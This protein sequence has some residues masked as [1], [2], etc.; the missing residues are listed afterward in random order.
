MTPSAR[1]RPS[2]TWSAAAAL[3]AV[4]VVRAG[5]TWWVSGAH[6]S[7]VRSPDTPG[8]VTP[9][10]SLLDSGVFRAYPGRDVPM[11][12][13]TPG[14]PAFL[15]G[16]IGLTGG[17]RGALMVQVFVSILTILVTYLLVIRLGGSRVAAGVAAAIV[18]LDPLQFV[19]SGTLLTESVTSLVMVAILAAGVGLFTV[20]AT[21]ARVRQSALLGLA[22]AIATM[23][24]PTT[25]YLPVLIVGLLVVHL[26]RSGLRRVVLHLAAFLLPVFVVVGAWQVRN[27]RVVNSWS[28]SQI[29][30]IN[31]YCY[32]G[33]S[34]EAGARN[35]SLA[36]VWKQRGC[37]ADGGVT[38]WCPSLGGCDE[39]VPRTIGP[40]F[41]EL[42][43]QGVRTTLHYP[44]ETAGS[45]VRGGWRL[46][47][48][49]GTETVARFLAVE[50]SSL[51]TAVLG[52]WMLAVELAAALGLVQLL[53]SAERRYWFFVAATLAYVVVISSGPET[54][55]RFRTPLV[56]LIA[57]FAGLWLG[58]RC[59]AKWVAR[60]SVVAGDDAAIVADEG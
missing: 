59:E 56:P 58:P 40:R 17:E 20:D 51:L 25:Y 45:T 21:A 52:V 32:R 60:R 42:E 55:S 15:A 44:L 35:L 12:I 27:H 33:A 47:V 36:T 57:M 13:R 49:P 10:R 14:Y 8:Y 4:F 11:F 18:A 38:G 23:I 2:G 6:P 5:W 46:L 43:R 16:A 3:A 31:L 30:A 29:Q 19:A 41:D 50:Q 54:Y 48:G 24:R 53:R 22:I 9:A 37:P 1:T 26:R 39:R 28:V 7:A 34:A